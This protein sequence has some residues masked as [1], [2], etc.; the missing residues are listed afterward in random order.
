MS[1]YK[2]QVK[3]VS[4]YPT[5]DDSE[6]HVIRAFLKL[7]VVDEEKWVADGREEITDIITGK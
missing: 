7:Q 4:L 6:G 1:V 2:V 3:S 5:R